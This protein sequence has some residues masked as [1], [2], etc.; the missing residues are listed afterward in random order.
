VLDL[1]RAQA[2]PSPW[3]KPPARPDSQGRR[4]RR[5]VVVDDPAAKAVRQEASGGKRLMTGRAVQGFHL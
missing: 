5:K 3:L 4:E 2:K 1:N